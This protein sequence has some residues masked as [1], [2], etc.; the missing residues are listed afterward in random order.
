MTTSQKTE[1][2]FYV[3]VSSVRANMYLNLFLIE[4]VS[5]MH[6]NINHYPTHQLFTEI[7]SSD[8]F[9]TLNFSSAWFQSMH[10]TFI[11]LD[12]QTSNTGLT[13]SVMLTTYPLHLNES[14]TSFHSIEQ[15]WKLPLQVLDGS[16]LLNIHTIGYPHLKYWTF[17]SASF[18]T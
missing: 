18:Q 3:S 10:K 9:V 16:N 1:N 6:I 8:W 5:V 15:C 7:E 13:K 11:L 2:Y 12:T 14:S 4:V 17:P